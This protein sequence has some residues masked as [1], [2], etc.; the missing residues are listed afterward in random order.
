MELICCSILHNQLWECPETLAYNPHRH[1]K[2][3]LLR[4]SWS[5]PQIAICR[6]T[7]G[8]A[9]ATGPNWRRD[10]D[11]RNL[12]FLEISNGARYGDG[13]SLVSVLS[14]DDKTM[15]RFIQNDGEAGVELYNSELRRLANHRRNTWFKAPWLFAEYAIL[16]W[17]RVYLC[18]NQSQVLPVGLYKFHVQRSIVWR[19]YPQVPPSSLLLRGHQAL[20]KSRSI[21]VAKR[22]HS[23][24]RRVHMQFVKLHHQSVETL[25]SALRNC[26]HDV[27]AR[28]W[29][30]CV[31]ERYEKAGHPVQRDG[32]DVSLV[33]LFVI[34]FVNLSQKNHT[35]ETLLFASP[36][37]LLLIP[38]IPFRIVHC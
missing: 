33:S 3:R 12:Q 27:W 7:G 36:W 22:Y 34:V 23:T 38:L 1:C 20:A 8:Q 9:E 21:L 30:T 10:K 15:N 16:V 26:D 24:K 13:V 35:G 29:E 19:P 2:W 17:F 28:R 32:S 6:W 37:H 11:R 18:D 31:R 25:R 5:H 14:S 4:Q